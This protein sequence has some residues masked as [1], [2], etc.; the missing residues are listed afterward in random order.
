MSLIK[1]SATLT[2]TLPTIEHA[3]FLSKG[4]GDL[5]EALREEEILAAIDVTGGS[6]EEDLTKRFHLD[7]AMIRAEQLEAVG[8]I[9][10]QAAA[11]LE[12]EGIEF[13]AVLSDLQHRATFTSAGVGS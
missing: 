12:V 10:D 7:L 2:A 8:A 3:D 11:K 5:K 9:L 1:S 4:L 13:D 6:G